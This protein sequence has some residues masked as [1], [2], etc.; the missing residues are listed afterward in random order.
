MADTFKV[1]G[2]CGSLRK[3]SYNAKALRAAQE[4][5]P[6][7]ME[8]DLIRL[9]GIPL[10][11]R[12]IEEEGWPP[13]VEALREQIAGSDAV[14]FATPEYNYS[15]PGVMKNAIDWLSRPE[16]KAPL[17]GKPAAV[18]GASTSI[19]GTAR[20][21]AHFR[22]LTFYNAMPQLVT[23]EVLIFR[24]QEKFD[25]EGKLTDEKTREKLKS[26]LAAFADWIQL[27]RKQ[28]G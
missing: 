12:D 14:L 18:F 17:N 21:Q 23:S 20:A 5:A 2:I 28:A 26:F 11:N 7:G 24:A 22:D 1:A 9:T 10:Y 13:P 3:G 15:V 4:L 19:V 27:N 16:G 6:A 25:A 8:I